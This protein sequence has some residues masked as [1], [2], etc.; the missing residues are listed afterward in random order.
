MT[1]TTSDSFGGISSSVPLFSGGK[2]FNILIDR[3]DAAAIA[4]G[5]GGRTDGRTDGR[6]DSQTR[7]ARRAEV[8]SQRQIGDRLTGGFEWLNYQLGVTGK[9]DEIHNFLGAW[10]KRAKIFLYSLRVY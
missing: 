3:R 2:R 5:K 6:M 7:G 9:I 1:F 10:P 4:G 8:K